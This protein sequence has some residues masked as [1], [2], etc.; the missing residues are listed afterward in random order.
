MRPPWEMSPVEHLL[1]VLTEGRERGEPFDAAWARAIAVALTHAIERDVWAVSFSETR[2]G[3]R[4]AFE[5][6]PQTGPE[7]AL[8]LISPE[9]FGN[10]DGDGLEVRRCEWCGE[11]LPAS[12]SPL[13]RYCGAEHR[14]AANYQR[15][16]RVSHAR[17]VPARAA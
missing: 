3:W 7:A 9:V 2:E 15:E 13:A 8:A 12:M 16:K 6:A 1:R 17:K 10:L 14:R 4:A 5:G 11:P